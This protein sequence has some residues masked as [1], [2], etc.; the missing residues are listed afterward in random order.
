MLPVWKEE[1]IVV[2]VSTFVE[3]LASE[4]VDKKEVFD[5]NG[6]EL[7]CW[8]TVMV[9]ELE[10]ADVIDKVCW[11]SMVVI[12]EKL[13]GLL[14]AILLEEIGFDEIETVDVWDKGV[15]AID[16][17]GD[18]IGV[19][20][21]VLASD[22]PMS[23]E[24]EMILGIVSVWRDDN[25]MKSVFDVIE[26][27]SET[28]LMGFVEMVVSISGD[29]WLETVAILVWCNVFVGK[30]DSL[31]NVADGVDTVVSVYEF[32]GLLSDKFVV[33][34]IRLVEECEILI[35]LVLVAIVLLTT[36][37]G[38]V[39]V[40]KWEVVSTMFGDKIGVTDVTLDM[41][42]ILLVVYKTE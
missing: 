39:F 19:L 27:L 40:V 38:A 9:M 1:V 23:I 16:S 8:D 24:L 6:S 31:V 32:I 41:L 12:V 37:A 5:I 36:N 2:C 35:E 34:V 7:L 11:D 13:D 20:I 3:L 10:Y 15:E 29:V 14:D 33:A 4:L 18:E 21:I 25:M 26:P 30:D 22:V 17:N 42:S 28:E